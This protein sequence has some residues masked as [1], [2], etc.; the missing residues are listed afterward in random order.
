MKSFQCTWSSDWIQPYETPWGIIEKFRYANAVSGNVVLDLLGNEGVKKLKKISSAGNGHRSLLTLMGI[1]PE[2]TGQILGINLVEYN[3]SII[4]T[5]IPCLS[6]IK[7]LSNYFRNNVSYCKLCL[8]KGYHSFFHQI[9]FFS[10]C[11]FHPEQ[12]I[13]DTC[14]KCNKLM[15][16]Y[17]I[18][19]DTTEAFRCTCGNSFL[20][21]HNISEIFQT[22]KKENNIQNE[23]V[24][25]WLDL[26]P[27]VIENYHLIFPLNNY[28]KYNEF[29]KS[30]IGDLS[31]ILK[32]LV[33]AFNDNN[34]GYHSKQVIKVSSGKKISLRK[35]DKD[36]LKEKYIRSFPHLL[37]P[38]AF[39]KKHEQDSFYFD[40]YHQTRSIYK[41]ISR[42]ILRN[43][44][45]DHKNC[46]RIFNKEN[47]NGDVCPYALAFVLWKME[48]EKKQNFSELEKHWS[49]PSSYNFE[50][51]RE[52]YTIFPKGNIISHIEEI[53]EPYYLESE[54]DYFSTYNISSIN[55][56][57]NKIISHL[58][59]E[60]F[61]QW[62]GIVKNSKKIKSIYPTNTFPLYIVKIPK[63]KDLEISFYFYENQFKKMKTM[64][65]DL[66]N[67]FNCSL[68][69]KKY[70]LYKS[71][72][73]IALDRKMKGLQ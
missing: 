1:R 50:R 51:F 21:S 34:G 29:N 25:K 42:Y 15:P 18:S 10:H 49:I 20:D 57:F 60:R 35:N 47:Q 14:L 52:D 62:L 7:N 44:I 38:A 31:K 32:L 46:V 69:S 16:E 36:Y 67:K 68:K 19:N 55:Y 3:D 17:L 48:F 24:K 13:I 65:N 70:P 72:S 39:K 73:R 43:I 8:D 54:Q 27:H 64:I 63:N 56:I 28:R 53:L 12:K 22:W 40:I 2:I 26:S 71:P 58:L 66:N 30:N 33:T 6:H 23:I 61:I 45:K 11:A 5:V 41:S 4:R 9:R 59:I 37:K